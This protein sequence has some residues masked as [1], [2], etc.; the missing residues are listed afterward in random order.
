MDRKSDSQGLSGHVV[1]LNFNDKVKRI[2]NELQAGTNHNGIDIVLVIQDQLLWNTKPEWR[3]AALS[4]QCRL[5]YITGYPTDPEILRRAGIDKARAAIILADPQHKEMADAPSTLT[6][7]AI[8]K[9]NPKVHTVIE[10]LLSINRAHL[11]ATE[12]NE[13]ICLGEISEKLIAQSCISPGVKNI[14]ENLL[15]ANSGTSQIFVSELPEP[16]YSQSF[17]QLVVKA[18]EHK[19]PFIIIGY[20]LQKNTFSHQIPEQGIHSPVCSWR[21]SDFI[22]NP[23][24][25]VEP[26]K[27]TPLPQGS[28]LAILAAS[29]PDLNRYLI[30]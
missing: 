21:R 29:K 5:I 9:Q 30:Q 26:G 15:N 10:L 16:L 20:I 23:R 8:E 13:V 12:V 22:I 3:P 4:D 1:I 17:R 27:D 7:I 14:F 28:S 2:V 19:A 24:F 25:G 18:V 6:A 11:E